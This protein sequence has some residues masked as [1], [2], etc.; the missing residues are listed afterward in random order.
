MAALRDKS[1]NFDATDRDC[2][3]PENGWYV[4][5]YCQ[6]LP[7]EA[8]GEPE[9]HGSFATAQKLM[10]AYEFADPAIIRAIYARDS[11]LEGRDMLLEARWH[12]LKFRFGVRVTGVIDE[13]RTVDG[14]P[15]RGVGME[16]LDPRG[17]PRDRPD[18]LRAL[19]VA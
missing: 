18:G 19:E 2:A 3:S 1:V 4:D 12:G 14:R 13:A 17:A 9:P 10:L 11:P 16:L 15:V 5:D 8:P 7:R 6:P